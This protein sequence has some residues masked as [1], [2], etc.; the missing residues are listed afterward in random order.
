MA[1]KNETAAACLHE[2]SRKSRFKIVWNEFF[3]DLERY[4]MILGVWV[5]SISII[6]TAFYFSENR[7]PLS[8]ASSEVLGGITGLF[9]MA[10]TTVIVLVGAVV[11]PALTMSRWEM[12][13]GGGMA[14]LVALMALRFF[15][16]VSVIRGWR[17]APLSLSLL[18][19]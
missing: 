15:V 6:S 11:L 2:E 8:V 16:V 19:V 9:V 5:V 10:V 1:D 17:G 4:W 18:S 12:D 7:I 14:C 13:G 3:G